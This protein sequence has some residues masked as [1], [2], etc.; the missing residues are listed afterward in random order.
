VSLGGKLALVFL[1]FLAIL[2]TVILVAFRERRRSRDIAESDL[3]GQQAQD[4]RVLAVI[5]G[6]MLGGILLTLLAA[7]LVFL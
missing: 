5:F 7:W 1:A 6:A 4:A 2:V 3:E